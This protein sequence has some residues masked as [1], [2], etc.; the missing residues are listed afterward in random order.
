[1]LMR[2]S[3][4]VLG[5]TMDVAAIMVYVEV[6]LMVFAVGVV[7]MVYVVDVMAY[8]HSVKHIR[9]QPIAIATTC[10]ITT[11]MNTALNIDTI[12]IIIT[13]TLSDKYTLTA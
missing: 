9:V 3:T 7:I 13:H 10:I 1:M 5:V 4:L 12:I 11:F 8:V 2:D 6:V